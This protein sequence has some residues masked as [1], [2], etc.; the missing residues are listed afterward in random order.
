MPKA[1]GPY[2]DLTTLEKAY[3]D[4][5]GYARIKFNNLPDISD[6]KSVSYQN[7]GIIGRAS[8][9]H[10]YSHSETRQI[11]L[12]LHFFVVKEKDIETNL[13]H[14]RAI[15]SCAYPRLGEQGAPFKPPVICRLRMG[16]I[17]SA[18]DLCVV[19]QQ[20]SVKFPTEVA[21]DEENYCPYKFDVDTS[22]MV[23]Y[24]SSDLPHQSRI[25]DTGR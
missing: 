21:Y 8:P 14:L 19:M 11:S 17:L 13:N 1:T 23:V 10:T 12:Q 20:Y 22:W 9:I 3:L 6:S 4:I 15:Q 16:N 7:E 25:I 2:G 5:P 24:N 18:D